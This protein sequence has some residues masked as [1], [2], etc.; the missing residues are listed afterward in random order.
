MN[1]SKKR[2]RY[3]KRLRMKTSDLYDM[4]IPGERTALTAEERQWTGLMIPG[5]L[6]GV[7]PNLSEY[8]PVI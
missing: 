4:K 1:L 6:G 2:E 5:R 8:T 7:P 3:P